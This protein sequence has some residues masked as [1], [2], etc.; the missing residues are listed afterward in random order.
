VLFFRHW[1]ASESA[2][3][4]LVVERA[5]GSDSEGSSPVT[6]R[7]LAYSFLQIF[8]PCL[9][10]FLSS[11][12][13]SSAHDSILITDHS[14]SSR[15]ESY[16][17]KRYGSYKELCTLT[18]KS[19]CPSATHISVLL[20]VITQSAPNYDLRN[21]QCF[22]FAKTLWETI[23]QLFPDHIEADWKDGRS[24]YRGVEVE[25]PDSVLGV[26]E[27]YADELTLFEKRQAE[28]DKQAE[29]EKA[30]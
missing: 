19:A 16:L 21:A 4:R 1:K 14:N 3:E 20:F 12:L 22:W 10:D 15:W 26:C 8:S 18:F 2:T 24:H 13:L 29:Q 25:T 11:A 7:L 27:K 6:L 5:V 30:R 17:S 9:Q 23:K 28:P